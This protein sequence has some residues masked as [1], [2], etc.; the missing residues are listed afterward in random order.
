MYTHAWYQLLTLNNTHVQLFLYDLI[1]SKQM[2]EDFK[3]FTLVRCLCR[4][5]RRS[6]VSV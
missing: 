1:Q 3:L 5:S 6:D 4:G 2:S